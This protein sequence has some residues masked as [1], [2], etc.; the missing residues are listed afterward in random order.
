MHDRHRERSI[1]EFS[2][3]PV[4]TYNAGTHDTARRQD[5][6]VIVVSMD[7]KLTRPR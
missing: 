3:S 6:V 4:Q 1:T 2:T 7:T 5:M